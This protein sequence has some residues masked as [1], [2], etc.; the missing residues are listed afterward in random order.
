[1]YIAS[2]LQEC[3]LVKT[4][5]QGARKACQPRC[6]PVCSELSY[7]CSRDV[8]QTRLCCVTEEHQIT[9]NTSIDSLVYEHDRM[10]KSAGTLDVCKAFDHVD[11][12]Q[13][14]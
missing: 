9:K 2:L 11:G 14:V 8:I 5:K 10:Y 4:R 1:M 6:S 3:S 13:K 12:G 7:A